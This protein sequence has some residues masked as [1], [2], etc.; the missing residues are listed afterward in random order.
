MKK[1]KLISII[2]IIVVWTLLALLVNN[3]MLVPSF[4]SVVERMI[5]EASTLYFYKIVGLTLL[6]MLLGLFIAIIIGCSLG[7]LAGMYKWVENLLRPIEIIS[8]AVPNVS[9]IILS[10]IW[11]GQQKSVLLVSFLV[12]YPIFYNSAKLSVQRLSNELKEVMNIY[13]N[14]FF[15]C[16]KNVYLP[17]Y[18]EYFLNSLHQALS[19]GIKV[20]I[21]AEI[22]G[23]V[24]DSIGIKIHLARLDLD[25][26]G[27]LCWTCWIII[28]VFIFDSLLK[29]IY[30]EN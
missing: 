3:Q 23:Q 8:S 10:L 2:A 12:L 19:L 28:I 15:Y 9:Y 11:L 18:K 30:K 4:F 25:T 17:E 5:K 6:R 13:G 14:R 16:I 24:P 22:L 21:M 1:Y 27:V 29:I 26:T 7:L 20:C